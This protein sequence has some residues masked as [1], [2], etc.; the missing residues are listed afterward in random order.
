MV[1]G[2]PKAAKGTRYFMQNEL[3][4]VLNCARFEWQRRFNVAGERSELKCEI[5]CPSWTVSEEISSALSEIAGEIGEKGHEQRAGALNYFLT[6]T[7]LRM[8]GT[9][10]F[11][12]EEVPGI[13]SELAERWYRQVTAPYEDGAIEKNGDCF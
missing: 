4:G 12:R 13:F 10:L 8:A 7:F 6:V 3:I 2:T 1:Y 11:S 5:G 9:K